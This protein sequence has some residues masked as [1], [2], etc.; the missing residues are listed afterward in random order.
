MQMG[1]M[2][3]QMCALT[4]AKWATTIYIKKIKSYESTSLLTK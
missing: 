3:I 4:V 2:I 1:I